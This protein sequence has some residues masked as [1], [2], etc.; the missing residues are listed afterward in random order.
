MSIYKYIEYISKNYYKI[1]SKNGL[2]IIKLIFN[3]DLEQKD[4]DNFLSNW[5]IE[6]ETNYSNILLLSYLQDK[7]KNIKFNEKTG[8]RLTG[9]QQY[10][11]FK[12]I[13]TISSFVKIA[14]SL[15]ENNIDF[16]L[17]KGG[18]MKVLR[19]NLQRFMGDIDILVKYED[20]DRAC[21]VFVANGFDYK[22]KNE[23]NIGIRRAH[24]TDFIDKNDNCID[25]HRVS[26]K[27]ITN[28]DDNDDYNKDI[29][30]KVK[31]F[32]KELFK[33]KNYVDFSGAK[34]LLPSCEDLLLIFM[35]NL[36]FNI[37]HNESEEKLIFAIFDFNY[38]INMKDNFDWNILFEKA[39]NL[40]MLYQV[41][42]IISICNSI[43]KNILNVDID[44][45]EITE[46]TT[47][48]MLKLYQKVIFDVYFD[49]K[50]KKEDKTFRD[51]CLRFLR[52]KTPI[53]NFII[54]KLIL[55]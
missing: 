4:I 33:S 8:P 14:K 16:I 39:K 15:N 31:V 40:N 17:F 18:L 21:D 55:K 52:S 20:F 46:K 23:N 5:N 32:D 42:T 47:K 36:Y 53:R 9:L 34:I 1:I 13:K 26:L 45:V 6:L 11:K 10:L 2:E 24:A 29:L 25:L 12:N 30:E 43:S 51:K 19:P 35:G 50:V 3:N 49:F 7:Y 28:T 48:Q 38:I 54:N 37:L 44:K 41:Y 22:Y 27:D